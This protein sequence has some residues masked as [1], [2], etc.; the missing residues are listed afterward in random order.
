[1]GQILRSIMHPTRPRISTLPANQRFVHLLR[2]TA[3]A[4]LFLPLSACKG[5]S[6]AAALHR[7]TSNDN[8]QVPATPAPTKFGGQDA[9]ELRR[10]QSFDGQ[11]PEFTSVT[12]LPG[13][14]MDIISIKANLPGSGEIQVLNVSPP[15]EIAAAMANDSN[16]APNLLGA[17]FLAPFV[18]PLAGSISPDGKIVNVNVHGRTMPL[19][20][21]RDI[22]GISTQPMARYGLLHR[23][24]AQPQI[25]NMPDGGEVKAVFDSGNFGG[26]WPGK[27]QFTISTMLSGRAVDVVMTA[28]NDGPDPVPVGLGWFPKLSIP[29]GL[30]PQ[31]RLR[32][33]IS[34]Q[35]LPLSP[36]S[37]L[38][39]DIKGDAGFNLRNGKEL[40]RD[41]IAADLAKMKSGLFDNGPTVELRD[42]AKDYGIRLVGMTTSINGIR[43]LAPADKN[44][45]GVIFA[46]NPTDQTGKPLDADKAGNQLLDPGKTM[47]WRV[48]MELFAPSTQVKASGL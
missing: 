37:S 5:G 2:M 44:W 3:F 10:L 14:A 42:P 29:S 33:P 23:M 15:Q 46:A 47:Q 9:F 35:V 41:T 38:T 25:S 31:A 18:T 19:P 12:L 30:R 8:E 43:I 4:C 21:L 20:V 34:S 39:D 32:L 45:V 36:N 40:G 6:G 28:H 13:R 48:R 17:A 24:S 11:M 7:L 1:M 27:L 26:H 22:D 16:G